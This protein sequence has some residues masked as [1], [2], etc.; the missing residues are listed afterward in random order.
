MASVKFIYNK[1]EYCLQHA[2]S[3]LH[4]KMILTATYTSSRKNGF[5]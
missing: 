5:F 3:W 1:L 4:T 2:I